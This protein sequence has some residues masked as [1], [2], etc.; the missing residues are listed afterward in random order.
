M[1]DTRFNESGSELQTIDLEQDEHNY[2]SEINH[3]HNS[4]NGLPYVGNLETLKSVILKANVGYIKRINI[5]A[6]YQPPAVKK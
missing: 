5:Y 1:A 2:K 6:P 4:A 3:V